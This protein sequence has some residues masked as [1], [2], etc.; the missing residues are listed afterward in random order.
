IIVDWHD[1]VLFPKAPHANDTPI[2]ASLRIPAGWRFDTALT[3]TEQHDDVL[4][5]AAT[6]LYTLTDSPLLASDHLR[7]YDLAQH[8]V[9]ERIAVAGDHPSQTLIPTARLE[10]YRRLPLEALELFGARH[11]HGYHWLLALGSELDENGLEHH[12][13]SDDRAQPEM[14]TE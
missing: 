11:Y 13:S 10:D 7:I 1:L 4:R 8:G 9:V 3:V 2:V 5:F 6:T 12:E 14:F